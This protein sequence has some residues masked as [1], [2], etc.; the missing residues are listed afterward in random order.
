[1]ARERGEWIPWYCADSPSWLRLSLA[2]RGAAEGIARKMGPRSGELHLGAYGLEGLADLL[3]VRWEDLEPAIVELTSGPHPRLLV[4]EDRRILIDPDHPTR[5]LKG[6]TIRMHNKR[7]KEETTERHQAS[8]GV[9][10][11]HEASLAVTP[12]ILFSSSLINSSSDL[13]NTNVS[14]GP[15]DNTAELVIE[16][17]VEGWKRVIGGKNPPKA[18]PKR[19]GKVRARLGEG[20]TVDELKRAIDGMW[21]SEF[22]VKNH[23][24][25]IELV[26]RD[27]AHVR[28]YMA[29]ADS[30]PTRPGSPAQQP[31][32]RR[33]S[34]KLLNGTDPW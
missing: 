21:A 16:H 34:N 12:S 14:P 33:H 10:E 6:S 15:P 1:M 4:T 32:V 31:E 19:L 29:I 23:H 18:N 22:N 3:R 24:T 13:K 26:C 9:T 27:D 11:C 25:D 7:S 30:P 17:W 20:F 2:A 8:Q 5:R 28:R